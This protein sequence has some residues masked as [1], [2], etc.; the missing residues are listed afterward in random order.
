VSGIIRV[1]KD[2]R[3]FVASNEPF[4]NAK[5]SWDARGVI[6]YLMTKPDNWTCRNEDLIR[7]G[8]AGKHRINRIIAELKE[9]GYI[10]R[11]R[12]HK[13]DGTFEWATEVYES[14]RLNPDFTIDRLS[15]DGSSINGSSINGKPG[16][17]VSTDR[18]NTDLISTEKTTTTTERPE[19]EKD[20]GELCKV[21]EQ[22][23]GSLS[24]LVADKI[25]DTLRGTPVAWCVKAVEEAGLQNKRRWAYVEGILK[26]WQSIGGPQNAAPR[27][28]GKQNIQK[29][30]T[31]LSPDVAAIVAQ[32]KQDELERRPV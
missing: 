5:L 3:Y 26:N 12:F 4:Q 11:S 32:Y 30:K 27:G 6:G 2:E 24:P 19:F 1:K 23:I 20:Y 8:P 22:E 7:Q 16:H 28:S 31:N 21:Y 13:D 29:P 9:A 17:I 14:P 25:K 10:R 18:L 15:I